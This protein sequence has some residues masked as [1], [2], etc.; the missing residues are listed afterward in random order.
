[1]DYSDE[2]IKAFTEAEIALCIHCNF[3]NEPCIC[4]TNTDFLA[5]DDSYDIDYVDYDEYDDN[6]CGLPF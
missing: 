3:G 1:M 6:D 4:G 2:D 5:D